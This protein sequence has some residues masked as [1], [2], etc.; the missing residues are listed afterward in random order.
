MGTSI[1]PSQLLCIQPH[2]KYQGTVMA[3]TR[4]YLSL[5]S[6]QL[7]VIIINNFCTVRDTI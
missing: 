6:S 1:I 5:K 7:P 3:S 4:L 2:A